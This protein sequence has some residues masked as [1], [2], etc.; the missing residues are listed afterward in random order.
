[1]QLYESVEEDGFATIL[2][3]LRER[4]ASKDCEEQISLGT[5]IRT[6]TM[7]FT[8][9]NTT[10]TYDNSAYEESIY[11]EKTKAR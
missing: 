6:V 9:S 10:P 4:I 1:M 8:N 7:T 3:L 2:K 11:I 5:K